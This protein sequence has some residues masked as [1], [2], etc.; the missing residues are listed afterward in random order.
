MNSTGGN[1][2]AGGGGD[3]A[4]CNETIHIFSVASGH[5]Y[6]RL[7]RI[8]MMSVREHTAC[9]LHFWLIE[10]F[11]SPHFRRLL[12]TLAAKVGFAVSRVTYKWPAWLR[13]QTEKQRVI[14]AY[15]ILFLDV[16]FPLQVSRVLFID[17]D[18]IVRADVK[19]LWDT[20]LKG[21]VYG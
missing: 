11:L 4:K 18:Q 5:R 7:L 13:Q 9:P 3:P 15:K 8:M 12:P 17:A 1:S 14:W 10:N 16:L 2:Y 21:Q 6:E 20:D 19:E